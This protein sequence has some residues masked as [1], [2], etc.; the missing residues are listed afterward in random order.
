MAGFA[1][2]RVAQAFLAAQSIMNYRFLKFTS[3]Y[4]EFARRFL[5]QHTDSARL[6]YQG[7]LDRFL[8]TRY[9]LVIFPAAH[10]RALGHEV[11]DYYTTFEP[12]QKAWAAECGFKYDSSNW[13]REIALAQVKEFQPEVV[14]LQDL[15]V[16]DQEL[17]QQIRAACQRPILLIG[18]RAAPTQDFSIFRD[19]D[20]VLTCVPHFAQR[21]RAEGANTVLMPLAFEHSIL[22]ELPADGPRPFD[23]TFAGSIG[24][25]YGIWAE[26]EA[27][28]ESLMEETTLEVWA[29]LV[30]PVSRFEK[31][32]Y[33]ANRALGALGVPAGARARLPWVKLGAY[34][35]TDPGRSSLKDRFPARVH[36]P[37]FARDYYHLLAQSKL[38]FNSHGD[39]AENYA[40]NVRLYEA[41]GMGACLL[42]DWKDNLPELFEP[43]TEVVT[44]RNAA[45]CLEKA[46][47]LLEHEKER[48]TI[49][50]AG[51]RR[52]LRDHTCLQR[53]LQVD[54]LIKQA[55]DAR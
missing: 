19:L 40:G 48:Q 17:R 14:Y 46:R 3:V 18:W 29:N 44:Y 5:A 13:L 49:A 7:L 51:Q 47:Y 27:L 9:G 1:R 53:V 52:T 25:P 11:R 38:A 41:T 10:M 8:R 34:G 23:F 30:D 6:S 45:E 36:A 2:A 50:A 43:D 54:Q 31:A 26:R 28:I 22:E 33:L 12:L 55:L 32:I 21:L 15:Y 24:S 39:C 42:T 20:L 16:C 4:P 37:V 35:M